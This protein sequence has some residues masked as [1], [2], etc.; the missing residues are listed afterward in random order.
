MKVLHD[1]FRDSLDVLMNQGQQTKAGDQNQDALGSFKQRYDSQPT[2]MWPVSHSS[3]SVIR[4]FQRQHGRQA[5][6]PDPGG[7][8][9]QEWMFRRASVLRA[10]PLSPRR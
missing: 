6:G 3:S 9:L 2:M 8:S 5:R 1:F 7:Y 10:S 4:L